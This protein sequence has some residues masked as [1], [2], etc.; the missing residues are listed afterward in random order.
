[1][2]K[3]CLVVFAAV[4]CSAWGGFQSTAL[5]ASPDKFD[6]LFHTTKGNF[7]VQVERAFA[8]LGA[9]RFYALVNDKFFDEAGFF[10]VVPGFVV[11]FGLA[12][13]PEE[14]A[15]WNT[16]IPDDPVAKSNVRSWISFATAGPNTRTSQL[17][18]NY[19][20][21]A[22]LDAMGFAPFGQVTEGM[23]VADSIYSGYGQQPDQGLITSQGDEYLKKNFPNLDYIVTA[24]V[25]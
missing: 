4:V 10:R 12:A 11:Q 25:V 5:G 6:V 19:G 1:M 16:P 7:T 24:V 8:P 23:D 21:N 13:K 9:D 17:F 15:K 14:T 18:I 20:D 2:N 22:R 3:L